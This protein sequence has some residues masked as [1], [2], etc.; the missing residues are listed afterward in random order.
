VGTEYVE[1]NDEDFAIA[2]LRLTKQLG[3]QMAKGAK[4]DLDIK[5]RLGQIGY[6]V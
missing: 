6:E 3:E 5:Q 1:D 4:L 2:M